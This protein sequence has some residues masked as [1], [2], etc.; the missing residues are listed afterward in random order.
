[1]AR[2]GG[3]NTIVSLSSLSAKAKKAREICRN[4]KGG[5]T[6]ARMR[7]SLI[8]RARRL[9]R[10]GGRGER[11]GGREGG[12]THAR[13]RGSLNSRARRLVSRSRMEPH[14]PLARFKSLAAIAYSGTNNDDRSTLILNFI[15]K[16]LHG[17]LLK[18]VELSCL[19]VIIAL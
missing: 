12:Y 15:S 9:V 2:F 5:C 6:H 4:S 8:S 14:L 10:G 17:M 1:M 16:G 19:G 18:Q 3:Y 7:G 11:I 13:M